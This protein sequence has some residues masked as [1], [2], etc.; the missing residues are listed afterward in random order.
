MDSDWLSL[1]NSEIYTQKGSI[2]VSTAYVSTGNW[3]T[4]EAEYMINYLT[5]MT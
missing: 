2:L 1:Y 3:P 5:K 4:Q